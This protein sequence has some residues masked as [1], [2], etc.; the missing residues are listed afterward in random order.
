[1]PRNR[2]LYRLRVSFVL[3]FSAADPKKSYF[4][5]H[6]AKGSAE[7]IKFLDLRRALF[8]CPSIINCT[9]EIQSRSDADAFL[10]SISRITCFRLFGFTARFKTASGA[11]IVPRSGKNDPVDARIL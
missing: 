10:K 1:M 2:I 9:I 3:G 5:G 8:D 7:N 6:S 4:F 11:F